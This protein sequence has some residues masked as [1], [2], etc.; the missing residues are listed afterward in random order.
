M[1]SRMEVED[2]SKRNP[3]KRLSVKFQKFQI[4]K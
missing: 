2:R 1:K 4:I 3:R